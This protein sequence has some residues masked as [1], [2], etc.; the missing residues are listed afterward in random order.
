MDH[1]WVP[2]ERKG[3]NVL[4]GKH[5]TMGHVERQLSRKRYVNNGATPVR[6]PSK[7][8]KP[9]M[10][11]GGARLFRFGPGLDGNETVAYREYLPL[12]PRQV[13]QHSR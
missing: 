1:F 6:R 10:G 9:Y 2:I 4:V 8:S 5:Q 3:L 12:R 13:F 11:D 7:L